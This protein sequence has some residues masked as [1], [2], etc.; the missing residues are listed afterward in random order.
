MGTLYLVAVPIGNLEDIT[1]RALRILRSVRRI[2]CEDTRRTGKLLGLLGVER[3]PLI[4]VHD[5]N[6]DERSAAI[7]EAIQQGEDVALVSDAGTPTISDPGFKLVRAAIAAG[8]PVVPIPGVS[9]AITALCASGLPTDA[10]RFVGFLPKKQGARRERLI[11]LSTARETLILF[12]SPHRLDAVLADAAQVLGGDRPAV[13]AREL[14]KRFEEFRRGSL[15]ELV[16]EPGTI[17]GEIVLLIGGASEVTPSATDLRT[18]VEGLLADGMSPSRAA[19]AAAMQTGA[20]KSDAYR[21]AV[22][23]SAQ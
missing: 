3:P 11:E 13:I 12:A 23:L 14:T 2:A 1:V 16:A 20:R 18:V 5:H 9:A 21:L 7:I 10:F 19:K 4:A 17:R 22:E 6:E 8:V 15:A